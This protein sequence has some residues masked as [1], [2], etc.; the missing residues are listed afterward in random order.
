LASSCPVALP[1]ISPGYFPI[2]GA[3]GGLAL[4]FEQRSHAIGRFRAA[5]NPEIHAIQIDPQ[6]LFLVRSE[7]I[8]KSQALDIPAVPTI[9]T[10]GNDQMIKRT[11]LRT[12]ARKSNTNHNFSAS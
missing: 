7:R 12:T 1:A 8:E 6:I 10:V 3:L 5:A 4:N 2:S 11:L 9:T